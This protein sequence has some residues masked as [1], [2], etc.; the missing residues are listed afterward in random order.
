MKA[1]KRRDE[2][3]FAPNISTCWFDIANPSNKEDWL[4]LR[5][6]VKLKSEEEDWFSNKAS[7]EVSVN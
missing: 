4:M 5:V 7:G 3:C 1:I 2:H 6:K